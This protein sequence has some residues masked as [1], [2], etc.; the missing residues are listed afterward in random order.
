M[1]DSLW[2][3]KTTIADELAV[4]DLAVGPAPGFHWVFFVPTGAR[5]AVETDQMME[6]IIDQLSDSDRHEVIA[7]FE[8]WAAEYRAKIERDREEERRSREAA[9][10]R[11][12]EER[13][14]QIEEARA[15]KEA[16]THERREAVRY[17]HARFLQGSGF[18]P[19][20]LF[21]PSASREPDVRTAPCCGCG[22]ILQSDVHDLVCRRCG[23]MACDCGTCGCG[24]PK[25]CVDV[26]KLQTPFFSPVA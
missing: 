14:R 24:H 7:A 16:A 10:E 2:V 26:E 17:A 13:E 6:N 23:W 19:A 15:R 4:S 21:S 18:A 5:A 20:F 9:A 3:G 22:A 12:Q 11:Q 8:R 25:G 1:S